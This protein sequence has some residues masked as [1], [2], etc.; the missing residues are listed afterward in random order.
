ME[1]QKL[2]MIICSECRQAGCSKACIKRFRNR[3]KKRRYRKSGK[4]SER[5]ARYVE[6]MKRNNPELYRSKQRHK[7]RRKCLT[8]SNTYVRNLIAKTIQLR[9]SEIPQSFV[10]C[11]RALLKVRRY[12]LYGIT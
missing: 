7:S 1:G 8:L 6:R 9:Q 3:A 2:V 12:L 5:K 10:E 4:E 11:K